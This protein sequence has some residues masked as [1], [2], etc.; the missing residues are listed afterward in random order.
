[1]KKSLLA[2]SAVLAM[3]TGA[4]AQENAGANEASDDAFGA[5]W[6]NSEKHLA[7]LATVAALGIIATNSTGS[8]V[9][10]QPP[11]P[12]EPP[13][14]PPV[15]PPTPE[16]EGDDPLV[17]G[18]CVGTTNTVTV[19]S[20]ATGTGTATNTFTVTVPVTFTYLPTVP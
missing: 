19:S 20:T 17:D 2:I 13:V 3:S 5:A 18:V 11:E 10:V 8:S 6:T 4:V 9:V 14:E 16:C 15:E 1:M 12:P 7:G